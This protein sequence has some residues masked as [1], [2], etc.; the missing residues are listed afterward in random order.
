MAVTSFFVLVPAASRGAGFPPMEIN[1]Y[2]N[3]EPGNLP[4]ANR[5][6]E[7]ADV[8][9]RVLF[10]LAVCFGANPAFHSCVYNGEMNHSECAFA[11]MDE[12]SS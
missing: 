4:L 3:F 10:V 12:T 11:E 7:S 1:V 6:R 9:I 8:T 2:E 5:A